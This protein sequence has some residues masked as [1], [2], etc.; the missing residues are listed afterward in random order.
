MSRVRI[1]VGT[2]K[3][4]FVLSADGKRDR[5]EVS[6]PH[7]PGWEV[8]HVKGSP[9]VPS[10]IYA[11]LN[12]IWQGQQIQ[13]SDNGGISWEQVGSAFAFEGEPGNHQWYTGAP[14]QWE[15]ARIWHLE[16][17]LTDPDTVYAGGEDAALF[18]T[19]DGGKTWSELAGLRNHPSG[20]TWQAGP[21]GMALHSIVQDPSKPERLYA[22]ISG[23]GAFRSDDSGAT[24]KP[25][26]AGLKS[27]SLP[28][29]EAEA[30]HCVHGIALHA[31]NP[32]RLYMQKHHDV[33]RSDDA[34]E[35]WVEVSGNLPADYGY[36]IDVHA[37]EGETIY[38]VPMK[39]DHEEFPLDGKLRVYRSRSGGTRW[40]PL[41]TGLPQRD[42][43]VSVLREA[44]SVD[45]LDPCGV[46][47]GTT[48]GAVYGSNDAGDSWSPIVRDLP[49]VYSV[50]VQTLA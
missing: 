37:S 50:E 49:A 2:Q 34:G 40:E 31:S 3:G 20:S 32:N 48:G 25:I 15:F 16:P 10:R 46:Y 9:A 45:K 18:R 14:R 11:S 24:W 21:C 42:C 5:W 8:Y 12:S 6:G 7:F 33:M 1:L 30:G 44:M 47:F 23:G 38:V 35:T 39:G 29:P 26:N 17:S 19:T 43:Y 41:T 4:A 27:E 36:P 22:A 13:R 28:N